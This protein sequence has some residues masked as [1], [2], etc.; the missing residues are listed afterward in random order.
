MTP[1][2]TVTELLAQG[3]SQADLEVSVSGWVW[4]RFEHCAIYDSL[5]A[6]T[7]PNPKDGIW[8]RGQLPNRRASRG[9]GPLHRQSVRLTG[10]FHWQPKKGAGHGI[11]GATTTD[12]RGYD[13][14][15]IALLRVLWQTMKVISASDRIP[16]YW[17]SC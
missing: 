10:K 2:F 8:L 5:T 14:G 7:D 3:A 15:Q 13:G 4:D 16:G 6:T 17:P 9:D 12:V 11:L 1:A